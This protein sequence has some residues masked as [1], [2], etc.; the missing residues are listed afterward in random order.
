MTSNQQD[1]EEYWDSTNVGQ[2]RF[3]REPQ[4]GK[5]RKSLAVQYLKNQ[6]K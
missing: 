5:G 3:T 1:D 2:D 6:M 4:K